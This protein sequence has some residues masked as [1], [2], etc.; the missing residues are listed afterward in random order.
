MGDPKPSVNT[1]LE[2]LGGLFADG[3]VERDPSKPRERATY[4]WRKLSVNLKEG[5]AQTDAA[6]QDSQEKLS[7]NLKEGFAQTD[8][9]LAD[10]HGK[11]SAQNISI[12]SQTVLDG[13]DV[14]LAKSPEEGVIA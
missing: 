2:V 9:S 8:E 6:L 14:G 10:G 1:L 11:L 3:L 12:G 13:A 4:R 7:V 5:F